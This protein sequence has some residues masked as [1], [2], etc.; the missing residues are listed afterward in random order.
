MRITSFSFCLLAFLFLNQS[1]FSQVPN[2]LSFQAVIRNASNQL[3]ISSPVGIRAS[4]L[5]GG[6]N[7]TTIYSETHNVTSNTNGL[8]TLEI[9]G[10]SASSGIYNS[11]DWSKG[12]YFIKIEADPTGGINY[13][14][15]TSSQILSVPYALYAKKSAD[16]DSLMSRL[17]KLDSLISKNDFKGNS[18]IIITGSIDSIALI[19]KIKNEY[20]PITEKITVSLANALNSLDFSFINR[21]IK[22][23]IFDNSNLKSIDLS[24]I[25]NIIGS[26]N[27]SFQIYRN[28]L[29]KNINLSSLNKIEYANWSDGTLPS[30]GIESDTIVLNNLK[31]LSGHWQFI[32]NKFNFDNLESVSTGSISIISTNN[33]NLSFNNLNSFASLFLQGSFDTI[34]IPKVKEIG[35]FL[36]QGVTLKSISLDSVSNIKAFTSTDGQYKQLNLPNLQ[37]LDYLFIQQPGLESIRFDNLKDI[38]VEFL[39]NSTLPTIEINYILSKLVS[40]LQ[41]VSSTN[42]AR[43][44]SIYGLTSPSGQGLIDKQILI[45]RGHNVT[46][47]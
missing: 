13:S 26:T 34:N 14:I 10:G 45:S 41:P 23:E 3:V 43:N 24:N 25:P 22:L 46:T 15:I 30:P 33:A 9:G 42:P 18:E 28:P 44:I 5:Q 12:N 2:N 4:I 8:V 19:E 20:G 27:R 32:G 6:A 1:V 38:G 31:S 40:I 37:K 16:V 7:G 17:N 39:I 21:S 11:V 47:N 35:S 29:L 36:M